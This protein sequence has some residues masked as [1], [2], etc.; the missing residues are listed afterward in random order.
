[1]TTTTSTSVKV[2]FYNADGSLNT[3]YS[4]QL[5]DNRSDVSIVLN[6]DSTKV[7][8]AKLFVD[9]DAATNTATQKQFSC[10]MGTATTV[11]KTG[12]NAYAFVNNNLYSLKNI[13][14]LNTSGYPTLHAKFNISGATETQSYTYMYTTTTNTF[15]ISSPTVT[16]P[17]DVQYDGSMTISAEIDFT[18]N[19]ADT[20]KPVDVV[21]TFDIMEGGSDTDNKE[22]LNSYSVVQAY[23]PSG[24]YNLDPVKLANHN[25]YAISLT[26]VFADGFTVSKNVEKAVRV[27]KA[28]VITKVVPYG[29]GLDGL[30]AGDDSLSSVMDVYM[31]TEETGNFTGDT[32]ILFKL[33]QGET[34]Y[35]TYELNV[36][37]GVNPVYYVVK[38]D[39][40][41]TGSSV[42][43]STTVDG[44]IFYT[45][46]VTAYRTYDSDIFKVSD[47]VSANFTMDITPVVSVS[48]YNAWVA[49]GVNS[50]NKVVID[51]VLTQ[52]LWDS[53]PETGFVAKFS[54]TQFFGNAST[55]LF[56]DLDTTSTKFKVESSSDNGKTFS[57]VTSLRMKQG[58][59]A[60]SAAEDRVQWLN[61]L[62]LTSITND[63]GLYTN[64][65]WSSAV[66]GASQ[67]PIYIMGDCAK[68]ASF[69]LKVSIVAEASTA[70]SATISNMVKIMN[71]V[72]TPVE[73]NAY[74]SILNNKL[75]I[76]VDD[77]FSSSNDKLTSVLLTSNL[78]SPN[79]SKVV[80][81]PDGN[82]NNQFTFEV[83][84]PEKRGASNPV[85]FQIKHIVDDDNNTNGSDLTGLAGPVKT[86]VCYNAP[87]IANF[88][89]SDFTY[90]TV[91]DDAESSV[92]FKVSFNGDNNSNIK[93]V[94]AYFSATGIS[95]VAV[96]DDVLRTAQTNPLTSVTI[97]LSDKDLYSRWADLSA[98]TIEFVPLYDDFEDTGVA[99]EREVSA[100]KSYGLYKVEQIASVTASLKGGVVQAATTLK[101]TGV[102]GDSY[103]LVASSST[104]NPDGDLSVG[105]VASGSDFSYVFPADTL[106]VSSIS[107]ALKKQ[108]T[109]PEV[110]ATDNYYGL[111]AK[112]FSAVTDVTFTPVSVDTS[113]MTIDVK[114]GSNVTDLLTTHVAA[115]V[116]DSS[117]LNL[118]ASQLCKVAGS[119][120]TPLKFDDGAGSSDI[121]Q[122]HVTADM[123]VNQYT[124]SE[125]LGALL[126][127]KMR[128][129]AGVKY[130]TQVGS[131]SVSGQLDS[132]SV[133]LPLGPSTVYRV[134]GTPSVT[135]NNKY[136]VVNN[137]I[138]LAFSVNSNG[139]AAEGLT[140][141]TVILTQESNYTDSTDTQGGVGGTVLLSYSPA[142]NTKSYAVGAD[143]S[144]S[145]ATDN[146]AA[147]EVR[148]E[149]PQNLSD[150]VHAI[151]S[152]D[153][154]L[155][156]GDLTSSES[157]LSCP[158]AGF[159]ASKPI[160]F[161]LIVTDRLG[162]ACRVDVATPPPWVTTGLFSRYDASDSSSYT[163]S[164]GNVTQWK[165]LTGK[166]HHLTPNGTG[167][168]LTTIN[169][170]SA[171]N[172]NSNRG[173][174]CNDVPLS[175]QITIFIVI[176]NKD[177]EGTPWGYGSFVHHGHR[178]TDWAIE[179]VN[180]S[181]FISFQSNNDDFSKVLVQNDKNYIIVGRIVGNT[182][183]I[184]AYSE[185]LSPQNASGGTVTITAGNK[186]LYVG[187]SENNEPCNS[188]IGELLYY[189]APL[190]DDDVN[191][192]VEYLKNKWFV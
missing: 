155:T 33:S 120:V 71:K 4:G 169:S 14:V 67:P 142:S 118:T 34:V 113:S 10:Q 40:K 51:T 64:T 158:A 61:L 60:S 146:L 131:D 148:V 80:L 132:D 20:R 43:V 26:A 25:K 117:L 179:R 161:V 126:D 125:T 9:S 70:P 13:I 143:A 176:T 66:L 84:S 97:T 157:T 183:Q 138:L 83:T 164:G 189:N 191:Q 95:S 109:L 5:H 110:P 108:Q 41:T 38:S 184:W 141:V 72:N 139:L 111:A 174:M 22:A 188:I 89:I 53:S 159:D 32:K 96:G 17:N 103:N 151:E 149:S 166:G 163:L 106:S 133:V 91:N 98:G 74:Y 124:L 105:I 121:M 54:K 145:T 160:S 85:E 69:I 93:G 162:T 177:I 24:L 150:G 134:A 19:P 123:P 87:T 23:E 135:I 52:E 88:V 56:R 101:W 73:Q 180:T 192:N 167:P 173:L 50:D 185:T 78:V 3:D 178:D 47:P 12:H 8:T 116:S 119:V 86:V 31:E 57:P 79:D 104:P 156:L 171:F 127:L 81:K 42:P 68:D 6:G 153:F 63:S 77:E 2:K 62:D 94:R 37:T 100:Q 187:K 102:S 92:T 44:T 76:K 175:T 46:D 136:T 99:V 7:L 1:M 82:V 28:P 154:T 190:H 27:V 15:S 59:I 152:G 170:K 144:A 36:L 182:R 130:T 181:D 45:F 186:S 55:G 65:P 147:G 128:L 48:V 58:A 107:L 112:T 18:T 90:K 114:R 137:E 21:F 165:D 39:L 16:N 129:K 122:L 140:A 35:Y 29:L 168:T 115:T 172:F 30:G 11:G 75:Y 49:C